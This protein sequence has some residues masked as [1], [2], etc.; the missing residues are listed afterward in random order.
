MS[1]FPE[2]ATDRIGKVKWYQSLLIRYALRLPKG[3]MIMVLLPPQ[4]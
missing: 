2:G 3:A 1:M 4:H